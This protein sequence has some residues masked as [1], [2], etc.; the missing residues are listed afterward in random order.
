[1]QTEVIVPVLAIATA[2][3]ITD[4]R[5][6]RIPNVLTFGGAFAA[7]F[8]RG[9]LHG[10]PGVVD[11][12]AGWLTGFL[13]LFPLFFVRGLGAGDVKL[14]AA[15]GAWVGT[16]DAVWLA[17]YSA[18]AGGVMG[19]AYALARGYLR[20]ALSNIR[21]VGFH[22]FISGFG[23]VPG[24]TLDNPERLRMPYALPILVGT[25]VTLWLR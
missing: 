6:H 4:V 24:V 10:V 7:L 13:I 11:A 12:S 21:V 3:S 2:A 23:P 16:F 15:L 25:M 17:L 22:W 8:V 1:M 5:T 20:T 9:V 14:V 19:V 18:I